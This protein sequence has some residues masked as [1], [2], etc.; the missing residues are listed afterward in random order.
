[1]G[2]GEENIR[3]PFFPIRGFFRVKEKSFLQKNSRVKSREVSG[4]VV[5]HK[6]VNFEAALFVGQCEK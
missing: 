2:G 4:S 3:D 5:G 6:R 1:M